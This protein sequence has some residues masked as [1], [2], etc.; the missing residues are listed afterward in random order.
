MDLQV[1]VLLPPLASANRRLDRVPVLVLASRQPQALLAASHLGSR[2][3]AVLCLDL[4]SRWHL[5]LLPQPP[6]MEE[7]YL[8][9]RQA[10]VPVHSRSPPPPVQPAVQ[11]QDSSV[12]AARRSSDSPAQ[13]SGRALY[14]AITRLHR[15]LLDSALDNSQVSFQELVYQF[16]SFHTGV[17]NMT[18]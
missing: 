17:F 15:P 12:R 8:E 9:P 6:A 7:D 4:V 11:V 10:A 2:R 1:L 18:E 3:L 14:L 13:A 5:Q 16:C